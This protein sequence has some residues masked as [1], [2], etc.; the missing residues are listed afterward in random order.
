ML[1]ARSAQS[2]AMAKL[3]ANNIWT[4]NID[5]A[6][7]LCELRA[8][9]I[10]NVCCVDVEHSTCRLCKYAVWT[11]SI[12]GYASTLCGLLAF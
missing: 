7:T 10:M 5:Y 9:Q 3:F 11:S 2:L 8:Y 1:N 6:S 12:L 4:S